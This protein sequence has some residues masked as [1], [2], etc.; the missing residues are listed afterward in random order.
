MNK[1]ASACFARLIGRGT[2]GDLEGG[3]LAGGDLAIS[4]PDHK[5]R[6]KM[7]DDESTRKQP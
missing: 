1:T 6:G 3:N 7:V 2:A 4:M 5:L